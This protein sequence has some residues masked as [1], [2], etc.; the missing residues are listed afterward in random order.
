M[1]AKQYLDNPNTSIY[2]YHKG[3]IKYVGVILK[4][5]MEVL[6]DQEIKNALWRRGDTIFY[7]KV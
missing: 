3:L 2:F 4:E 5:K 6:I 7:K 1:R